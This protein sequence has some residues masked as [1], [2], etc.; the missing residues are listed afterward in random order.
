MNPKQAFA[1]DLR[2]VGVAAVITGIIG[3][4]L[5]DQVPLAGAV[6]ASVGGVTSLGFGYY[7]HKR[8]RQSEEE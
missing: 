1:E 4:F 2:R 8:D 6:V 7:V 3:G 5:Q